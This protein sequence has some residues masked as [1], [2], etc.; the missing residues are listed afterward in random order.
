L[1]AHQAEGCTLQQCCSQHTLLTRFHPAWKMEETNTHTGIHTHAH[2]SKHTQ[3]TCPLLLTQQQAPRP[4]MPTPCR[5]QR[6]KVHTHGS[7]TLG[8]PA[9][10]GPTG[11]QLAAGKAGGWLRMR[12]KSCQVP[13]SG[14]CFTKAQQSP[15]CSVLRAWL[16]QRTR[17]NMA[18][19]ARC[20]RLR[21]WPWR[22]AGSPQLLMPSMR[23][24][25]P[26][27]RQ[28]RAAQQQG[29]WA[30]LVTVGPPRPSAGSALR[31]QGCTVEATKQ[32][33]VAQDDAS[34]PRRFPAA[35]RAVCGSGKLTRKSLDCGHILLRSIQRQ[36]WVSIWLQE[37]TKACS[38]QWARH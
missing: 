22:S 18:Q 19:T 28:T 2:I 21:Q 37:V 1:A 31:K 26:G 8:A 5:G 10:Q 35:A 4:C 36:Q 9:G 15:G 20:H 17:Y 38:M 6:R 16:Q 32:N 33:V 29:H 34:P 24:V 13:Q 14:P 25:D 23:P 27:G 11:L 7:H 12:S 30:R 3:H